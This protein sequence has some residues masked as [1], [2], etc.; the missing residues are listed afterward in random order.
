MFE[1]ERQ[2]LTQPLVV[3]PFRSLGSSRLV[4]DVAARPGQ[5]IHFLG[6]Y[7]FYIVSRI[8]SHLPLV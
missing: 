2:L 3:R 4:A 1:M 7:H 6:V 8:S 5:H